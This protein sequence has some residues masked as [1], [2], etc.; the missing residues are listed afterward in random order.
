MYAIA[1][2]LMMI[3]LKKIMGI[4]ITGLTMKFERN[5]RYWVLN[6][7]KAVYM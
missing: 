3:Y 6:G 5:W 1:F 7:H 4:H 2:D